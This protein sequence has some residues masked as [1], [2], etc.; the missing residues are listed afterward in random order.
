MVSKGQV[1]QMLRRLE[2]ESSLRKEQAAP[3]IKQNSASAAAMT[4]PWIFVGEKHTLETLTQ[5]PINNTI[6]AT[7]L[8][9]CI[10]SVLVEVS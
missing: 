2:P 7:P 1:D 6:L 10:L 9:L 3:F 8:I 4:A 5:G